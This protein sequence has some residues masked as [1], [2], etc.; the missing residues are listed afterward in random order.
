[1]S[2]GHTGEGKR[3]SSSVALCSCLSHELISCLVCSVLPA[4]WQA[5]SSAERSLTATSWVLSVPIP[6]PCS[7][8]SYSLSLGPSANL[9]GISFLLPPWAD[10]WNLVL[11]PCFS[12]SP[13]HLLLHRWFPCSILFAA[14]DLPPPTDSLSSS[15][16]P[17]WV[18][19]LAVIFLIHPM[20][21]S[22]P[23]AHHHQHRRLHSLI[24]YFYIS[25]FCWR[26]GDTIYPHLICC[27]LWRYNPLS[28]ELLLVCWKTVLESRLWPHIRRKGLVWLDY[29]QKR[30]GVVLLSYERKRR[31]LLKNWKA[32]SEWLMCPR[33]AGKLC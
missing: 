24:S 5:P 2:P 6:Y 31:A 28:A 8:Q 7:F 26:A 27:R 30:L 20:T 17:T 16:I 3:E 23:P 22:Y 4:K 15:H 10:T 11:S 14:S 33:S 21:I 29:E 25:R 18:T 1:M 13:R 12:V 9:I 32:L 19:Y